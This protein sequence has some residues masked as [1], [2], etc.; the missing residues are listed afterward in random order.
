MKLPGALPGGIDLIRRG[1]SADRMK[2]VTRRRTH[3]RRLSSRIAT[4]LLAVIV[5]IAVVGSLAAY[6]YQIGRGI[7]PELRLMDPRRAPTVDEAGASHPAAYAIGSH[8]AND[9]VF[10]GDSTCRDGIDPAAFEKL[11]G[12]RAFNL[13]TAQGLGPNG[14]AVTALAYLTEHPK[15]AAI[16]MCVSPFCFEIDTGTAG[17]DF[18]DRFVAN[19]GPNVS[20]S[21]SRYGAV[22]YFM[23]R[24]TVS[25][26]DGSPAV[27]DMPL[28]G[29]ERETYRSLAE[30]MI[31][32]RGY[33]RL[34]GEHGITRATPPAPD[35]IVK[36]DWDHWIRFVAANCAP[37]P[38]LIQF[39]PIAHDDADARDWKQLETWGANLTASRVNATVARPIVSAYDASLMWD[40]LHLN[41]RGTERFMPLVARNVED[42]LRGPGR[43]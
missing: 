26:F 1:Y 23:R 16:V 30:K 43:K 40:G 18:P 22:T 13:G 21:V 32:S 41:R 28:V 35:T 5:P 4:T 15:P 8:E 34:P 36:P 24:G 33:F 10:F 19:Y 6:S 7:P 2:R 20:G 39:T 38:L 17:G 9:V 11:T 3:L 14:M 29:Y 25:L 31:R 37:T 42:A 27:L 12:L